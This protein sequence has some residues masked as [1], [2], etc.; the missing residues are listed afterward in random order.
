MA[1]QTDLSAFFAGS[2]T[3]S[4]STNTTTTRFSTSSGEPSTD[5]SLD[6]VS[7]SND[8]PPEQSETRR[9]SLLERTIVNSEKNFRFRK[10]SLAYYSTSRYSGLPV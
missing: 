10:A 9:K 1:K 6:H 5:S 7:S 4:T 8:D 2:D 3:R